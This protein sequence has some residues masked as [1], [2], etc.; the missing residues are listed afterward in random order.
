MKERIKGFINS[1]PG[2]RIPLSFVKTIVVIF[3]ENLSYCVIARSVRDGTI[4]FYSNVFS[5]M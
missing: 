3:S 4:L 5:K 1:K 2:R